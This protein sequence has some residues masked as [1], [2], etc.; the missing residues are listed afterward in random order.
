MTLNC[1]AKANWE[2]MS[3]SKAGN[4]FV[5]VKDKDKSHIIES[6]RVLEN[7]AFRSLPLVELSA[8]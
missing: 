5:S 4:V 1:F 8:S 6:V 2:P 7:L 3:P